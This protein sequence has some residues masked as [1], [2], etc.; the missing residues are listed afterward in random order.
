MLITFSGQTYSNEIWNIPYSLGP[1][2]FIEPGVNAH[3]WSPHLHHGKLPN[4]FECPRSTVLEAHSTDVLVN[5]GG[6]FSCYRLLMA[7]RTFF[8][9]P[10]FF[11]G[12]ILPGPSWK[13]RAREIVLMGLLNR[14]QHI[15]GH[16]NHLVAPSG[17]LMSGFRYGW[18]IIYGLRTSC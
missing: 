17:K 18:I 6:V 8:F 5:V 2:G 3:I 9:S 12:A 11:A 14:N 4:F 13:G 7:E 10:P 15:P 1:D 16:R